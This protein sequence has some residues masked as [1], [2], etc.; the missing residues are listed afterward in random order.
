MRHNPPLVPVTTDRLVD[1]R[2][3]FGRQWTCLRSS[4]AVGKLLPVLHA[5][6]AFSSV[7]IG[8]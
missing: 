3:Q 4:D 6:N 5:E 8:W 1:L 2:Q 7:L